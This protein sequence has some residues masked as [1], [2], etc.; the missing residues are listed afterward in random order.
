MCEKE[1][2]KIVEESFHIT[3]FKGKRFL[4]YCFSKSRR[5]YLFH[6]FMWLLRL[7]IDVPQYSFV[8]NNYNNYNNNNNNNYFI[9]V[10][11]VFSTV[12]CCANWGHGK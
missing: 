5:I 1:D 12:H 6:L 2:I 4:L 9:L 3:Y 7:A 11:N 8:Y 10:S